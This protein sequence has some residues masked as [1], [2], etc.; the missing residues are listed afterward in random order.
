MNTVKS[1]SKSAWLSH[2]KLCATDIKLTEA[3]W[4]YEPSQ[5]HVCGQSSPQLFQNSVYSTIYR[6]L[7]DSLKLTIMKDRTWM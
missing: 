7:D 5:Y 4:T 2:T 3:F 6:I 1:A